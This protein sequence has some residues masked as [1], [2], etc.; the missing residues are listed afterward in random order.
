MHTDT[1]NRSDFLH[2]EIKFTPKTDST[3]SESGTLVVSIASLLELTLCLGRKLAKQIPT[4]IE[5][6]SKWLKLLRRQGSTWNDRLKL[7]ADSICSK[8]EVKFAWFITKII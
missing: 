8:R 4:A 6:D 5:L 7:V 1:R 2:I 3:S